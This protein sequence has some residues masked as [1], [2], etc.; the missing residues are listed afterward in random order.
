MENKTAIQM[1]RIYGLKSS[2]AFNK[3]MVKCGV[4]TRTI[5]GY[6]L[7]DSLRGQGLSVTVELPYFLPNGIKAT[8]KR[9]AWTEKGQKYIHQRLSRI[10]I[11]PSS[12]QTDLFS[13]L[14]TC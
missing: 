12:E 6:M 4:L 14:K 11:F 10:G 3:L 7:A 9:S 13:N 5:K 1:A 2:Q 8:K